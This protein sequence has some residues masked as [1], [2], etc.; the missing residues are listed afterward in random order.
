MVSSFVLVQYYEEPATCGNTQWWEMMPGKKW[1]VDMSCK[2]KGTHTYI[3]I[4]ICFSSVR[5]YYHTVCENGNIPNSQT[6]VVPFFSH[7]HSP[8]ILLTFAPFWKMRK[9]KHGDMTHDPWPRISVCWWSQFWIGY[10]RDTWH[11]KKTHIIFHR[12]SHENPW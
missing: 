8:F 3:Y 7:P 11:P 4:Y 12:I 1:W 6:A 5:S 2:R 9:Q 10:G